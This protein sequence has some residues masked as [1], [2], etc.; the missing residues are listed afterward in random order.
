MLFA[1][2]IT[3]TID[4]ARTA[5]WELVFDHGGHRVYVD[6]PSIELGKVAR[7]R[8]RYEFQ[9]AVPARD[10]WPSYL[11]SMELRRFDC[12]ARSSGVEHSVV[13]GRRGLRGDPLRALTMKAV[14][15]ERPAEGTLGAAVIDAFCQRIRA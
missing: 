15:M 13:Y 7:A 3:T 4:A 1:V 2:P 12:A 5:Q 8:L 14:A 6:A 9:A 10:G 11:S